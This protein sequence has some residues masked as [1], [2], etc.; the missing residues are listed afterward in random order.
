[1]RELQGDEY[2]TQFTQPKADLARIVGHDVPLFAYPFGV[3]NARAFPH[4]GIAGYQAAF[5]LAD[6][7]DR[8]QPLWTIRRIIVPE[9]SGAELLRQIRSDF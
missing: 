8:R 3:W 4:L 5:Q 9:W 7:L 1:V 2:K 6:K